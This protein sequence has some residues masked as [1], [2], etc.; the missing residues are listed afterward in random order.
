MHPEARYFANDGTVM[1]PDAFIHMA[2]G[3]WP[4]ICFHHEAVKKQQKNSSQL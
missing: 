3:G 1:K 2:V 4:G